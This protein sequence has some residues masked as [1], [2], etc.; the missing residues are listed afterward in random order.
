MRIEAYNQV[1]QVYSPKRTQKA[2][3]A[4][5]AYQVR[6][7]VE[8]SSIG[9]DILTAKNAVKASPDVRTD[10]VEP[11]K[12]KIKN[13]TYDVDPGAFADKLLEKLNF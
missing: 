11:I 13:G 8:I 3:A 7:N 1:Q 10:L 4:G 12:E 6:D 2:Q 5:N 9:K